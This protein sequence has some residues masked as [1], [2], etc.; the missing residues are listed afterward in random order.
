MIKYTF[1]SEDTDDNKK[2]ILSMDSDSGMW[3]EPMDLFF[4]FLKANGF[5]FTL[6]ESIGIMNEDTETFRGPADL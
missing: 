1:I 5:L 4:S 6:S 3:H 2:V